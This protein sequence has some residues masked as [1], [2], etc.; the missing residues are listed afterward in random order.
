MAAQD[1]DWEP[2][3]EAE[4]KLLQARR[5]RS[6]Q[7]SK[8]MGDYL[9]KGYKM[10]ATTCSV[11]D[12]ILLQTRQGE[13]Y[14]VSC[15][16]LDSDADKDNPA[17]NPA[18]A[19]TMAREMELTN[20]A[21]GTSSI[22]TEAASAASSPSPRHQPPPISQL[23]LDSQS[24]LPDTQRHRKLVTRSDQEPSDTL[25]M[26]AVNVQSWPTADTHGRKPGTTTTRS[27]Y[28]GDGDTGD[29]SVDSLGRTTGPQGQITVSALT[30]KLKWATQELGSCTSVEYS[31]QLCQLI[32][33]A[34]EAVVSVKSAQV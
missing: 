10:L 11:C 19:L 22:K 14:C 20:V 32:K 28:S 27:G 31:I 24:Q 18:A 34:S 17:L 13:N 33:A 15:S 25:G 2:L 6:D 5:E 7:I 3:S 1:D 8:R 12:T 30:D 23:D 16:E 29:C 9:L 4:M 26:S 21:T